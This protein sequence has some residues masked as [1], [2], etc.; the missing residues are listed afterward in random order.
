MESGDPI[1]APF[2]N[3]ARVSED[4]GQ[5]RSEPMIL[6]GDRGGRGGDG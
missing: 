2:G 5:T 1:L 6:S 4:G 3:Q